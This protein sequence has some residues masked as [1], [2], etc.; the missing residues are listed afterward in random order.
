MSHHEIDGPT[1]PDETT[2]QHDD[3]HHP[4]GE[5]QMLAYHE[6][7]LNGRHYEEYGCEFIGTALLVFAVVGAVAIVQATGSPIAAH[8][9]WLPLRL[10]LTG[11]LI[12]TSGCLITIS[13]FG[14]LSGAHLNP[15]I[16]FGFWQLGK[17]Q[18]RDLVGYIL[19]QMAGGIIG[20]EI[21]KPVFGLLGHEVVYAA[22]QPGKTSG[23]TIAFIGEIVCTFIMALAIFFFVS[24]K[25]LARWT[26]FMLVLLIPFLVLADATTSGCGM[27]PAR[28]I[29]PAYIAN[30]WV[31]AW[32]YIVGPMIGAALAVL[33]RKSG[34]AKFPIPQTAKLFHDSTY[35]SLFKHDQLPT[36]PHSMKSS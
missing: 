10:L 36:A 18:L 35:R 14:K 22:M 3:H 25:S 11:F 17:I 30:L 16:S 13:P 32:I 29:G 34:L 23:V 26:P 2:K 9:T 8:I 31:A 20:A 27:N 4:F 15:A 1:V 24:H 19:S 21:A 28:W 6:W 12:A 7:K 33:A 5:L